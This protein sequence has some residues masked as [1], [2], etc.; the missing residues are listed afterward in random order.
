MKKFYQIIIFLT[1]LSIIISENLYCEVD[2]PSNRE[3][4]WNLIPIDDY[5]EGAICCFLS[6]KMEGETSTACLS[7]V[8]D[9][10]DFMKKELM[11]YY[12]FYDIEIDCNTNSK[13]YSYYIQLNIILFLLLLLL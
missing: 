8:K 5:G 12:G 9:S 6:G 4:C 2:S 10:I 7:L 11:Q 13:S 3:V 1:V